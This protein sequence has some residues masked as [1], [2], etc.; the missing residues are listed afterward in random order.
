M[1]NNDPKDDT[2][3]ESLASIDRVIH[4]PV[5]LAI[6]A[7]L[8]VVQSVD[9]LFLKRQIKKLTWG[10]LSSH[11]SKL[12]EEGYVEVKKEFEGK[13]PHSMLYLTK[14]GRLAFEN[15][16]QSMKQVFSD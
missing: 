15:Y 11:V 3:L 16:R 7:H 1:E 8:Y 4:E 13:K 14:E 12:E 9:F 5:R 10:N 2:T 6:M